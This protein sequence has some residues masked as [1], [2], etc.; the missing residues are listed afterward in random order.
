MNPVAPQKVFFKA[1]DGIRIAAHFWVASS[2][3]AVLLVHQFNNSKESYSEFAEFLNRNSFGVL[4]LDLRGH[5][6]SRAS[7][8]LSNPLL[9]QPSDFQNM[10]LDLLAALDFLK[11]NRFTDFYFV[12]ASIGAN[13]AII[14]P[15]QN[16]GF[17][18]AVAL[19]PGLDFKSL[20]PQK[21][22]QKTTVSTLLVASSEDA[23]SFET[24]HELDQT[25]SCEHQKVELSNAGHG[26]FMLVKNPGL[27]E[28]IL[29]WFMNH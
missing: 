22:A 29:D 8:S 2:P 14:F 21:S 28:T 18:A 25:F 6:E 7:G 3:K 24:V 23:Y 4:A 16:P 13:L 20:L 10:K 12:G 17:R 27:S 9:L 19:S 15:A 26:T 1:A 11:Q 5:G